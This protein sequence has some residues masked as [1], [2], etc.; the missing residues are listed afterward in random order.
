MVNPLARA[1]MRNNLTNYKVKNNM[2]IET[3][4]SLSRDENKMLKSIIHGEKGV[5]EVNGT[6]SIISLEEA[7]N[8]IKEGL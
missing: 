3:E 5:V 8:R 1:N 6:N 4:L 2:S 7:V